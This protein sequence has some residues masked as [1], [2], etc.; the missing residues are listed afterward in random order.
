LHDLKV[1]YDCSTFDTDPFEP[2]PEGQNTIF[3]FWVPAP[4][5]PKSEIRNQKSETAPNAVPEF[6]LSAF[7]SR[8]SERP[9]YAELPYT[10]PQDSTVFLL[11]RHNDPGIWF[12]K[13]DWVAKHGGMALLNVHPDYLRFNGEKPVLRTYAAELYVQFLEYARRQYG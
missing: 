10:L 11:L 4:M 2:Q 6:Q 8:F 13:L 5:A 7:S 1:E 12:R 9:G 3:P